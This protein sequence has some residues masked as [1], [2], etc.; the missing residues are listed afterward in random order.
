M[1]AGFAFSKFA[2]RLAS[3]AELSSADIDLLANMPSSIAHYGSRH[4]IRQRG[5]EPDRCCLLLQGYLCWRNLEH[6]GQI[7]SV[8]VA[9]DVA[10][11]H[12]VHDRRVNADLV[13]LGPVVVAFVP[14]RFFREASLRSASMSQAFLL[15]LVAEMSILRNWSINL[16]SRD[17]LTRVAHLICEITFRLQAVGLARDFRLASPFTQSDLAAACGISSVHA[18]RTIQELRRSNLLQ[19]QSKTIIIADWAGLARLAGFDPGYLRLRDRINGAPLVPAA[20]SSCRI[21]AVLP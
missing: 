20:E 21:D 11:L 12:T 7:T 10:D 3:A 19:W 9:G 17:A 1:Q 2:D 5:D 16:A 4:V 15:Q 14:H 13:S 8:Y 18:N 6:D